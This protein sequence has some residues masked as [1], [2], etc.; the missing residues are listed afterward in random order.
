VIGT[1]VSHYRIEERIGGGGMGV[2]YRADDTRLHRTVALKFLP[3]ELTRDEVAKKRFL[4][5]AQA[6]SAIDHPNICTV[7]EIDETDDGQLFI[8]MAFYD[9]ESLK[10]RL[11]SGPL[12]IRQTLEIA[13]GLAQGLECAHRHKIIHRD[14]KPANVMVTKD[15]FVKIVD[16]GLAK[17]AGRSKM[18]RSG[19]TLGTVAYMA[20]EQAQGNEVDHRADLWSVG[21]VMYEMLTGTL[22]FRGDIDQAMVYSIIN[23]DP[24]PLS[25]RRD[26]VPEGLVAIVERCLQKNSDERYA[27]GAEMMADLGKLAHELGW[28]SA[29]AT[30][31]VSRSLLRRRRV[32]VAVIAAVVVGLAVAGWRYYQRPASVYT[33]DLR[34][35]VVPVKERVG[36]DAEDAF[37]DGLMQLVGE[38]T[39]DLARRHESAW[40]V[41][42]GNTRRGAIA[43]PSETAGLFGVNRVITGAMQRFRDGHRLTLSLQDA[44]SGRVIRKQTVDFDMGR[45]LGLHAAVMAACAHLLRVPE[46][47]DAGDPDSPDALLATLQAAGLLQ[48]RDESAT[49]S[50]VELAERAVGAD[51]SYAFARI[52]AARAFAARKGDGDLDKARAHAWRATEIAEDDHRPWHI[53]GGVSRAEEDRTQAVGYYQRAIALDPT[54]IESYMDLAS[55]MMEESRMDEAEAICA[56]AIDRAPDYYR[57]HG[58]LAYLL[59]VQGRMEEAALEYG[60]ALE[61]APRVNWILNNLGMI[62]YRNEEWDRASELFERAFAIE[63]YCDLALNLG[64]LMAY[65]HRFDEAESYYEFGAQYCDST[66]YLV[67]GNWAS[68]AYWLPERREE[69]LEMYHRAIRLA[70]AAR[71]QHPDDREVLG[72]L[73]DYYGMTKQRERALELIEEAAP[74]AATNSKLMFYVGCAYENL[75]ERENALRY[76]GDALRYGYPVKFVEAEPTL[77][78]LRKDRRFKQM[79]AN[80]DDGSG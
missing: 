23:E 59:H 46:A 8:S 56:A 42:F 6:A 30:I 19:S 12:T 20:P 71:T 58:N 21:V 34:L 57:P 49:S 50:A 33:T 16:F 43:G 54:D 22:P 52:T 14:V 72:H 15:G 74:I 47:G 37:Y 1:S 35:A 76:I 38:T 25:Q 68:V 60:R 26:D 55:T 67:W 73:I 7:Y 32:R 4:R 48:L 44:E 64:S 70:E 3:P 65:Q 53:L 10:Q 75:G 79:I 62:Y 39:H 78:E 45:P 13:Y 2:V 24:I 61:L 27:S 28:D 36:S 77:N 63:P 5:E 69:A 80:A 51:S 29:V 17:L 31:R 40:V 11:A 41:P 66:N 9:G 18:T